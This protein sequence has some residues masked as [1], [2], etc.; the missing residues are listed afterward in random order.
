MEIGRY[1][2]H[3]MSLL[4]Q[5]SC[6]LQC[7]D[8]QALPPSNLT[9][10]LMHLSM[11]TSAERY[12]ELI[13]DLETHCPRLRKAQMVRVGRL[14]PADVG[15]R[16]TT[17]IVAS[18]RNGV[19][20]KVRARGGSCHFS[21]FNGLLSQPCAKRPIVFYSFLSPFPKLAGCGSAFRNQTKCD[22]AEN[23]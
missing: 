5:T 13:T 22:Y 9:A 12:S 23:K 19:L 3:G 17:L 20:T 2:R 1:G 18:K 11:V 14:P 7:I 6:D 16:F 15:M 21:Y 8:L 10:S 4:P